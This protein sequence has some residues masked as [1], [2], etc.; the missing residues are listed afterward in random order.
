MSAVVTVIVIVAAVALIAGAVFLVTRRQGGGRSLER[1]FGPEYERTVARHDGD[2]KAAERELEER[3]KQH[4]SL[5]P[6]PLAAG[7]QERYESRWAAAQARFVD[8]PREAV[9]EVD[10]LLAELAAERGFPG[11]ERYEDQLS[12][13]SVH[14]AYQVNGYRRV[15]AAAHGNGEAGTESLREAMVEARAMFH[16]LLHSGA[17]SDG[18]SRTERKSLTGGRHHQGD[19]READEKHRTGARAET[20]APSGRGRGGPAWMFN[21][22][23]TKES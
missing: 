10:V 7:E 11:R 19:T 20:G 13:L 12:A 16:E 8:S 1:R 9:A 4:G 2:T 5:T 3:V 14:H 23:R 21:R 17:R 18:R 6:K 22:Q 15:H